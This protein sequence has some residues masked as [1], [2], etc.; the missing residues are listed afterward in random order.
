MLCVTAAG[1][2][3]ACMT[4]TGNLVVNGDFSQGNT[5]FSSDYGYQKDLVPEA[6]YYVTDDAH[7]THYGFRG[8]DHTS[9]K[10]NFMVVNGSYTANSS[11]W[12]QTIKVKPHVL[13]SFST[14]LCSVAT[15]NPASLQFSINGVNM[16]SPFTAPGNTFTWIQFFQWWDS[17]NDTVARICIVNQNTIRS[18]NDFGLDDIS[19]STCLPKQGATINIG[20]DQALCVGKTLRLHAGGGLDKYLWSNGSTDSFLDVNSVGTYWVKVT[21]DSCIAT[22]T[23]VIT[24]IVQPPKIDLGND[25]FICVTEFRLDAGYTQGYSYMWS[26]GETTPAIAITKS[27][28]YWVKVSAGSCSDSDIINVDMYN[29]PPNYLGPDTTLCIGDTLLLNANQNNHY[30]YLWDDGS[31]SP[32][33]DIYNTGNYNIEWD[34]LTCKFYDTIQVNFV[35]PPVFDLGPDT[36]LC[37]GDTMILDALN[38][39]FKHQWNT[40]DTTP[41]IIVTHTGNYIATVSNGS[42]AV[43]HNVHIN[44]S[45]GPP[46]LLKDRYTICTDLHEKITLYPGPAVSYLWLPNGETDSSITISQPPQYITITV[47]DKRGC[48]NSKDIVVEELCGPR[49]FVPNAFTPNGN[50][51]NEVFLPKG[52]FVLSY[53]MDIYNRWGEKIF[54]T[55]DVNQGWDGKFKGKT[56]AEDI[57][58]YMIT[59]GGESNTGPEEY[60]LSGILYLIP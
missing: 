43:K 44:F 7:N 51:L 59:Y 10:G 16:A 60:Y 24:A 11:V 50:K 45:N 48:K 41:T 31:T 20:P 12:C 30:T 22:D 2:C 23:M 27:G 58:I 3:P 42:C 14:W 33:R 21:K 53:K 26:T 46:I 6:F 54:V 38:I 19:F 13:Y 29:V 57:Y 1:Q 17:G 35:A 47:T 25:T 37:Y 34:L 40:G 32:K 5:G 49:L 56:C 55:T 9:G 4:P 18:G 8:S 39:D 52:V 36:I 15:G 28:T